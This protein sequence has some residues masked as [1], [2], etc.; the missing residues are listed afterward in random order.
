VVGERPDGCSIHFPERRDQD[1]P[2]LRVPLLPAALAAALILAAPASALAADPIPGATYEGT[3][4]NGSPFSFKVS[5]DGTAIT[6]ILGSAPLTCVGPEGGVEI[7][8][9]ASTVPIPVSGGAFSGKDESTTPRLDSVTGTFTSP[10]EATG[11]VLAA[12]SKFKIGEG[13]TSCMREL[14]FTAR[15]TAA[16]T[17]AAPVAPTGAAGTPAGPV[18]KFTGAPSAKLLDALRKGFAVRGTVDAPSTIAATARIGATD[19]RKYDLAGKTAIVARKTVRTAAAG[20]FSITL[21][22]SKTVAR[23][24]R[25]ARRI[26]VAVTLVS[27]ARGS[28][29]RTTSKRTVTLKR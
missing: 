21:K 19:A 14:T 9:L 4:D 23:K 11:K 15:T 17:P 12:T 8:A 29:A 7:F 1:A 18:V 27:T 5:P 25:R 6:D 26:K 20:P 16:A 24:L 2:M 10:T 3:S 13:V 28:G 22:P